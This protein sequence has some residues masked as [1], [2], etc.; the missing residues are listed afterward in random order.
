MM[1][2]S[3]QVQCPKAAKLVLSTTK[4]FR[5]DDPC[6]AILYICAWVGGVDIW[7]A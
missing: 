6:H 1:N 3:I 4:M 2:T 5:L 7:I